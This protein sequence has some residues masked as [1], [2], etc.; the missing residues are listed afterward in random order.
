MMVAFDIGKTFRHENMKDI[1]M[2]E[3]KLLM[4]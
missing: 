3:K 2:E 1:K 4:T